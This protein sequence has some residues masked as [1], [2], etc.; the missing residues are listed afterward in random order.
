MGC[1]FLLVASFA[2]RVVLTLMWIFSDLVDRAF[3]GFVVPL[4]GLLVLPYT[5]LFYVLVWSPVGGLSGW[6][7]FLVACGFLLD[8][9]HW[10]GSAYTRTQRA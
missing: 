2:P 7:W 10:G 4:L 9:S 5:T 1:L 3:S 6:E 8:I